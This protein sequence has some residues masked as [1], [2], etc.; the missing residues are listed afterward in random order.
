MKIAV[1]HNLP[2]GG[3]KRAVYEMAR[4]L[5]E[6]G[7]SV[8]EF[9]LSS[10][11]P[12]YLPLTQ[13]GIKTKTFDFEAKGVWTKRLPLFTPYVTAVRLLQDL[14][15]IE[16]INKKIAQ[17]ID[18]AEYDL[19]FSHD[20]QLS[21]NP[22]LLRFVKTP[23]VH[24]CHHGLGASLPS[25]PRNHEFN[26]VSRKL[27]TIYYYP[28]KHIYPWVRQHRGNHNLSFASVLLSNS[29]FARE[30]IYR[31]LGLESAVC[32]LGVDTK[33][34]RP[35]NQPR[36]NYV[37][38]VGAIHYH[39][40][41][42]FLI[43]ALGQVP[44]RIRPNLVIAANAQESAERTLLDHLAQKHSVKLT[45]CRVTDDDALAKLYSEA[46]LLVY[47]PIMEPWG[48]A[49]VEAMACGTPVVAVAEGGV[50]ESVVDSV[51]G[52]LIERDIQAFA[53]VIER[54]I[55]QPKQRNAMGDAARQH[56][57]QKYSWEQTGNRLEQLFSRAI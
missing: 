55:G 12:N 33:I 23:V 29:N 7:H 18:S 39:K 4:S 43:E 26:T 30:G 14:R 52:V 27:K 9:T 6:R 13:L 47:T 11:E 44:A 46:Q 15:N 48:L 45:V 54:L 51:T 2:S 24:Y 3:A 35:N 19:V 21:R 34:F 32:Y 16:R 41:Y 17:H 38:S 53:Q 20:C 40:G 5:I 57:L 8:D 37:L 56:V 22:A 42:R 28:A 10:A 1:F 49:A 25:V 36:G 50:R 31:S